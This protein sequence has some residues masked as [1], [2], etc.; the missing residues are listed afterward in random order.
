M[1][2]HP[3]RSL[4]AL[5]SG[6]EGEERDSRHTQH[7][8]QHHRTSVEEDGRIQAVYQQLQVSFNKRWQL[9]LPLDTLVEFRF[10]SA[11]GILF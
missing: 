4:Q 9:R 10:R 5:R 3:A 11:E 7:P 2:L 1:G 8:R 6:G